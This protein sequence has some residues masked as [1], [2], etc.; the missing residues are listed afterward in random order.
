LKRICVLFLLL[1]FCTACSYCIAE[2]TYLPAY[3]S[4]IDSYNSTM[5]PFRSGFSF[6]SGDWIYCP[7]GTGIEQSSIIRFNF[8]DAS[9]IETVRVFDNEEFLPTFPFDNGQAILL[10][11]TVSNRL[12]ALEYD[13]KSHSELFQFEEAPGFEIL[14]GDYLYYSQG[15]DVYELNYV[16]LE[17]RHIATYPGEK[18]IYGEY[19]VFA[20]GYIFVTV[21]GC[22]VYRIN[23]ATGDLFDLSFVFKDYPGQIYVDKS[24]VLGYDHDLNYIA[25]DY[26]GENK[27]FIEVGEYYIDEVVNKYILASN[28][29]L[30]RYLF[31]YEG[32]SFEQI[33]LSSMVP[34]ELELPIGGVYLYEDR[35]FVED[36]LKQIETSKP[37]IVAYP[38]E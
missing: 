23:V 7:S 31:K 19:A 24:A 22:G 29:S 5:D 2:N 28:D 17:N 25:T 38:I 37:C 14:V 27:Q 18:E 10:T 13:G 30:L 6:R 3:M 36:Y 33:D 11:D 16:T 15:T 34:T 9:M 1:V 12:I 32:E 20:Y 26:N 4:S 21:H 8:D 35:I